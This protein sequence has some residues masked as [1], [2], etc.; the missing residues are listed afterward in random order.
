MLNKTDIIVVHVFALLVLGFTIPR[1]GSV[2]LTWRFYLRWRQCA[3]KTLISQLLFIFTHENVA[4]VK[5]LVRN[6]I[7]VYLD[8]ITTGFAS[9]CIIVYGVPFLQ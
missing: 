6:P 7:V 5:H 3:V 8:A 4:K 2:S 9:R 1:P